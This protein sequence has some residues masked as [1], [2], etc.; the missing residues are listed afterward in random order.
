MM[1]NFTFE[2]KPIAIRQQHTKRNDLAGHYLTHG[3]KVA[4]SLRKV[5]DAG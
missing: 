2:V 3:I 5:S 1:P 4:A